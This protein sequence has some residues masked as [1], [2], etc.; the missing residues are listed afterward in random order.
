M[1]NK[2]NNETNTVEE[3]VKKRGRPRKIPLED[4]PPKKA[5]GR[6]LGSIKVGYRTADDKQYFNNYYNEKLKDNF[7]E[8]KFCGKTYQKC[9]QCRHLASKYC[10]LAQTLKQ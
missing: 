9:R 2:T 1:D 6:P 3:I 7:V 5:I 4:V 8:C 10:K